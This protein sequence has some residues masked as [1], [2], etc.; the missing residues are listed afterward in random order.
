MRLCLA[1]MPWIA[2]DTPSLAIGILHS[3]VEQALPDVDVTEYPGSLRWAAYLLAATDGR[4]T[5]AAYMRVANDG[6]SHGLGD[7]IFAGALYQDPDW[8]AGAMRGHAAALGDLVPQ[9]EL[10]RGLA[11]AFVAEATEEILRTDPD[12]VAFTTTFM[13]TVPSLAVARRIKLRRPE[14]AVVFGGANCEGP[15]GH[16]IHR[17]HRFVD[18]VVR[19][20]GEVVFPALLEHVRAAKQPRDLPGVCWWDGRASVANPESPHPVPPALI[21]TP[22]YDDWFAALDASPVCEYLSPYLFVEGSRGCWWG[23]RHHCT[24]CGLNDAMIGYRAKPAQRFW[25][26]LR[27]LVGRYRV[28]DVMTADNII[29]SA[30]YR[31]LLHLLVESGWDLRVQFEAKANVR[32]EQVALLAAAGVCAVQF[33]IESLSSRVLRLMDKGVTGT[34]NVRVLRH[35]EDHSVTVTWNYLYGFPGETEDDY[36]PVIGQMPALV[37]LQPPGGATRI[38][39]ERFSPYFERPEL[40]FAR[41]APL[42]FYQEVYDLPESELYDLAYFFDSDAA[43]IGGAV[44]L[45][46]RDAVAAWRRDYPYSALFQVTGPDGALIVRDRRR[47][48]PER[49]HHLTGWQQ[50]A[51][52]LLRRG[53]RLPA[54][55]RALA[56]Q[57]REVSQ[58]EL[59]DWL[60]GAVRDGLVYADGGDHVALATDDVPVHL[61]VDRDE[62]VYA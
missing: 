55:H 3:R 39:L 22:N 1:A 2:I 14:V 57:G 60:A 58:P 10:M 13:Q 52:R 42:P 62:A 8:R 32:A 30:Y 48:W 23:Q 18:Y 53:H 56:A 7:W 44:E 25:Q 21:P 29:D 51:Y 15:M 12:V 45:A 46:L 6:L 4:V 41:R 43:G 11:D 20:E 47:G 36:L 61:V 31:D 27:T 35:A 54:L 34:T 17:N 37:H 49:D 5:P 16:A 33:G 19:G 9:A 28:L 50:A 40:G 59:R 24:F 26:E 38:A